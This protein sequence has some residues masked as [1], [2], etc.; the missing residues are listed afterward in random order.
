MSPFF[1]PINLILLEV[2]GKFGVVRVYV[3]LF[4]TR[5]Y[6]WL[7]VFLKKSIPINVA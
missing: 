5:D 4:G 7:N 6:R 2:E 1:G 3:A